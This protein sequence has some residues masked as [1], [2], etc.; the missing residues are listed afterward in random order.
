VRRIDLLELLAS[1]TGGKDWSY[2][3]Q[4]QSYINT[5]ILFAQ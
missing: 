2:Q 4:Q 5:P 1:L 3:C